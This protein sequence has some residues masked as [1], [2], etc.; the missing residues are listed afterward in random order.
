M[1]LDTSFMRQF[2][3]QGLYQGQSLL[4]LDLVKCTRCDKCVEACIQQH[5]TVSHGK[6]ITR[7]R[8]EGPRFG[9]FLVATACR[10]CKDPY[11]MIGCPVDA[12]H[13]GTHLQIVIEDHC[14]GCGLCAKNCPY[15]NI[16]MEDNERDMM[17]V[18][19]PDHPGQKSK[20]ARPKAA[21]CDLCDADGRKDR[22]MPRCV[23]DCPHD[24]AHRMTGKDLLDLVNS[25]Q[26]EI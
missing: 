4:V 15:D 2:V 14:I 8:R 13:R 3:D 25:S 7:L 26:G 20:V 23:Y 1:K 6:A 16:F 12:I 19:D 17:E 11:C 22:A 5:G 10:S 21:T 18:D 9:D 24:A